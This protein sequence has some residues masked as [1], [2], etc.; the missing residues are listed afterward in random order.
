VTGGQNIGVQQ[1]RFI[2]G[3]TTLSR[4]PEQTCQGLQTQKKSFDNAIIDNKELT[5]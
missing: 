4:D 1:I 3:R 5:I 2:G